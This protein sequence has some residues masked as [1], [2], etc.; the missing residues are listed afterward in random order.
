[1]RDNASATSW[2]LGG[3]EEANLKKPLT[4]IASGEGGLSELTEQLDDGQVM[5]GLMRTSDKI[6]DIPTVKFVYIY[7]WVL[8]NRQY[9][10]S[11]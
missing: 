3:Y 5:Y 6:D 7:W 1:M 11:I 9:V 2:V 4:L 8:G 10:E